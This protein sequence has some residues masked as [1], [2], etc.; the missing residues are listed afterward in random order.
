MSR[1]QND[2]VAIVHVTGYD[3]N[4]VFNEGLAVNTVYNHTILVRHTPTM[5]MIAG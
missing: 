4:R 1:I 2:T 3:A 5:V